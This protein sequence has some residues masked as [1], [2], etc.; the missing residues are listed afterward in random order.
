MKSIRYAQA[1]PAAKSCI[2]NP[3][4]SH[5]A[6]DSLEV[7]GARLLAMELASIRFDFYIFVRFFIAHDGFID[8]FWGVGNPLNKGI[9][10]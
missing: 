2:G 8:K 9:V 6:N 4:N 7:A 5:Q 10:I 1:N 3:R